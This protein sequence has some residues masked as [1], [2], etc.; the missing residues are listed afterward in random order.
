MRWIL[1]I[2]I[3]FLATPIFASEIGARTVVLDQDQVA[4]VLTSPGIATIIQTQDRPSNV[5]IGN[6]NAFKV[7]YL[8]QAIT[9][10]PLFRTAKTNL[11][12]FTPN[13]RFVVKLSTVSPEK[14]DFIVYLKAKVKE[15]PA[16]VA[17]DNETTT[18]RPFSKELQFGQTTFKTTR[19]GLTKSG[20]LLLEAKIYSKKKNFFSP[21]SIWLTQNGRTKPIH[22]LYLSSNIVSLKNP[23]QVIAVIRSQ[24]LRPK[25]TPF[26]ELRQKGV[27]TQRL[28]LPKVGKW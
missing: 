2:P 1:L 13:R 22:N 8:D 18:W 19:M 5:V 17:P 3:L 6:L 14:A 23:I 15:S 12:I 20:M 9:V 21:E 27:T 10:K 24:D 7:E 25:S 26:L 11:Y 28:P 16:A 4:H